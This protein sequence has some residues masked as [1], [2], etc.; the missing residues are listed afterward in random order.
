VAVSYY[1]LKTEV[2]TFQHGSTTIQALVAG[3]VKFAA[4]GSAQGAN[5]KV[6]GA[7]VV[8]MAEWVNTCS[9]C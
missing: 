3:D 9:T 2:I 1:G 7:N 6:G 8:A 4:T 5:A